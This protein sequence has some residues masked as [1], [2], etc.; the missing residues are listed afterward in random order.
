VIKLRRTAGEQKEY[1]TDREI[2]SYRA[3]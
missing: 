2:T 3:V 1:D